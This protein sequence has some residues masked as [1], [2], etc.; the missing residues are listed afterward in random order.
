MMNVSRFQIALNH[1]D[2]NVIISGLKSFSHQILK[3]HEALYAFG[4]NG[5]TINSLIFSSASNIL[6]PYYNKVNEMPC[7]LLLSYLQSSPQIEELFIL[8][9]LPGYDVNK[10]L[11]SSHMN[12]IASILFCAHLD[13]TFCNYVI[14]RVI[15]EYCKS[16]LTQLSSSGNQN[17]VHSTLGLCIA[18]AR[19]SKQHA[20]DTYQK[21]MIS[22]NLFAT[23]LQ[24]GKTATWPSDDI[25]IDNNTES[26]STDSRLLIIIWFLL[27]MDA[28]DS[29]IAAEIATSNSIL[30]RI[31]NGIHKDPT[32][33]IIIALNGIK[34]VRSNSVT[35][36]QTKIV[37]NTFQERI[38]ELYGHEDENVQHTVN[39][40]LTDH[41]KYI[42]NNLKSFKRNDNTDI[43]NNSN[44]GNSFYAA[45]QL[46]RNLQPHTDLRLSLI[47]I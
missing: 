47:H 16:I 38:L 18:M 7:G 19:V 43:D 23:L 42:I 32:Y 14:N 4:Y 2:P 22:N 15:S 1:E 11:C 3:E 12:C 21:I 45:S 44:S 24:R 41:C 30:R 35:L 40:F 17:V 25:E 10:E 34:L 29:T 13:E 36:N 5:R 27:I 33:T 31:T 37:D 6:Y 28:A 8:W 46:I 20:C 9:N 39:I 26:I